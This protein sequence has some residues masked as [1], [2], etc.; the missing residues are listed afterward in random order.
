MENT[1]ILL[2]MSGIGK[3][4]HA[5][6]LKRLHGY[7]LFSID[8]MI[9]TALHKGDVHTVATFL[10][11]PYEE[12][13]GKRSST[14]L[15]LE[16]EFTREAL[17]YASAHPNEKIV[18]DTT[19]SVVHLSTETLVHIK[20]F[21]NSIFLDTKRTL[22]DAMIS[23]YLRQ[24]KPVIWGQFAKLFKNKKEYKTTVKELYP[25]LLYMRR[26]KYMS[27]SRITIDFYKHKR[28]N[29]DLVAFLTK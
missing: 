16:E 15:K 1:I 21:K 9:A 2:G 3:S 13:Y 25:K 11:A 10:G 23:L 12:E 4:Y 6:K 7:K 24:P 17:M 5:K 20:S 26:R 22:I 8:D 27:Y 28:K 18:I 19:G 29:F 14:Y